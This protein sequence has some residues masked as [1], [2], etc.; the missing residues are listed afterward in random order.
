MNSNRHP[1][2]PGLDDLFTYPF[3][4]CL[5][6][7]RTRRIARST[8]IEAGPLSHHSKNNPDP[9][10]KLEE[11]VLIVCTGIT[12]LTTHDGPLVKPT[13]GHE[14]GTP[15]LNVVARTAPSADDCQA[16]SFVI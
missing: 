5:M 2:H 4:S 9:L 7:R 12:G 6:E 1:I 8:S 11:A 16:T 13:G 15:F 3:M 10:S 14:L